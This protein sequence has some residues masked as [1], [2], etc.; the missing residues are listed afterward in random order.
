MMHDKKNESGI[1]NFTLMADIG[2]IRI[3]QQAS[4]E[5]IFEALDFYAEC[6]GL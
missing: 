2:D 5:L 6:F 4:K 3:N 1:I